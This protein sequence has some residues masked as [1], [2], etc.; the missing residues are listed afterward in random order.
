ML[1]SCFWLGNYSTTGVG[2]G[3]GGGFIIHYY[4]VTACKITFPLVKTT[5]L[6]T[7]NAHTPIDAAIKITCGR[8]TRN[9]N[10]INSGI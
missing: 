10:F 5:Q 4:D 9:M 7:T 3:G 1:N 2:G 6:L 8:V